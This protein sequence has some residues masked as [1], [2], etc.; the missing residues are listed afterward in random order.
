MRTAYAFVAAAL[1]GPA[2]AGAQDV[3]GD[4]HG[5]IEIEND[6]PLRLALHIS[7]SGSGRLTA[8]IDSIDE[9]GMDLAF[10]SISVSDAVM[11]FEMKSIGG[12]YRG[13]VAADGAAI[14]GS[15]TQN[16]TVWPL[17]WYRGE[18]PGVVSRP[19]DEEE[20]RRKGRIYTQLLYEGKASDL[21]KRLSPVMRQS[22]GNPA[23]LNEFCER[24]VRAIGK[25]SGPPQES[26]NLSGSLRVYRRLAKS[27]K[28]ANVE[29]TF[30]FD[31]S[32]TIA[33]FEVRS[34]DRPL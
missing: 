5:A 34:G 16:G 23:H 10:D 25:E 8:A 6:A 33:Q 21:W 13:N 14:V 7:R 27:G 26:V 18:D 17:T 9:G 22:F 2:L 1:V 30:G 28:S 29:I 31:S 20:A 11:K 19:L 3:I 4:W 15:W 24:A 32:G 12:A